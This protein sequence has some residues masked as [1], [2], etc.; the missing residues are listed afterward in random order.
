MSTPTLNERVGIFTFTP[1]K[2][3]PNGKEY[4]HINVNDRVQ[5]TLS[6]DSIRQF[7]DAANSALDENEPI[8]MAS[9]WFEIGIQHITE[10]T[11]DESKE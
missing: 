1:L 3:T 11:A 6:A 4:V 2:N 5:F 9:S 7:A 10:L 8:F